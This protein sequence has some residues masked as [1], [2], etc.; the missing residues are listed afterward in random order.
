MPSLCHK[1]A[2]CLWIWN[3]HIPVPQSCSLWLKQS[4][5]SC[6]HLVKVLHWTMA[7]VRW[8]G[9]SWVWCA[10]SASTRLGM[11]AIAVA[12]THW[13]S[14]WQMA[15]FE[16]CAHQNLPKA[17]NITGIWHG[18]LNGRRVPNSETCHPVCPPKAQGWVCWEHL[19]K[20]LLPSC[21]SHL[22]VSSRSSFLTFLMGQNSCGQRANRVRNVWD[23]LWVA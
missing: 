9:P 23:Y 17:V 10:K 8:K 11:L 16:N 6:R 19:F 2:C 1:I 21:P 3:L 5:K 4:L 22:Q 14:A 13:G 7:S 20:H 18:Y 12:A 15:L